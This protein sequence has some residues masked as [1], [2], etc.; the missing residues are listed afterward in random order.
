MTSAG[1]EATAVGSAA[2]LTL[3]DTVSRGTLILAGN[4]MM[5]CPLVHCMIK[6]NHTSCVAK[7]ASCNCGTAETTRDLHL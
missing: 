7:Y 6:C 5:L 3:E 1:E 2:A 4:C